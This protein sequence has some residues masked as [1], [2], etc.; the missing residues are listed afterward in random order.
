MNDPTQALAEDVTRFCEER[1]DDVAA[2]AGLAMPTLSASAPR[3][4]ALAIERHCLK[5]LESTDPPLAGAGVVVAPYVLTDEPYWLEWWLA[6]PDDAPAN[7][8]RLA[9]DVNPDSVTFRDYTDA[10]LVRGA[11]AHRGARHHRAVRRLPV[12]RPVHP[13]LHR[14]PHRRRPF[15]RGGGRGRARPLVRAAPV[16]ARRRPQGARRGL[17]RGQPEWPRGRLPHRHLGHRR[18]DPRARLRP[19]ARQEAGR[20]STVPERRS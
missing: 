17:R 9:A 19:P 15:P 3:R 6:G 5:L 7:A 8:T 11:A 12:H 4:S 13:H 1:F 16:R 18:P 20:S 10:G 2:I 14:S